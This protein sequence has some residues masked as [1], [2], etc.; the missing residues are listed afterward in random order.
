MSDKIP[1]PSATLLKEWAQKLKASGFKD[2]EKL[3]ADGDY[4]Y[5]TFPC[6]FVKDEPSLLR[7]GQ[8]ES[9][10]RLAGLFL[11]S[12]NF[13][14]QIERD[15]FALYAEGAT[16]REIAETTK[17]PQTTVFRLLDALK[18]EMM[19]QTHALIK[20]EEDDHADKTS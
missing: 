7:T 4:Y 3:H 1:K 8:R 13:L 5:Q 10:F 9:I 17:I 6:S 20:E 14:S 16:V 11:H 2:L 15:V 12:H 18:A 19:K